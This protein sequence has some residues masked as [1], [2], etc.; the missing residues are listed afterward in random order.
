MNIPFGLETS[1]LISLGVL[2][3]IFLYAMNRVHTILV[4]I[5]EEL[6]NIQS[7]STGIATRQ[8]RSR[9]ASESMTGRFVNYNIA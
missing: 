9:L 8:A 2:L 5:R 4:D 3:L 6:L 7:R 1:E